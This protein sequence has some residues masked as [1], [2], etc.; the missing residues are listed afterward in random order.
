MQNKCGMMLP[1]ERK[2]TTGSRHS[3]FWV[4]AR[5]TKDYLEN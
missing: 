1:T 2:Y 4:T 5:E 3:E